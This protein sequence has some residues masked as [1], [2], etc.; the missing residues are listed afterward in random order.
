AGVR[1]R[2]ASRLRLSRLCAP[3]GGAAHRRHRRS[4][5]TVEPRRQFWDADFVISRAAASLHDPQL[6]TAPYDEA[7]LDLT[8]FVSCYNEAPY[9]IG[10]LDAVRG[11]ATEAG[12]AYEI[13]V[14]DDGSRDASTRLVSD[15]IAANPDERIVLRVNRG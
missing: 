6:M 9:I 8:V 12:L 11:A 5:M 14:I 3:A 10:T 4:G 2:Q 1:G 7:A 15:Y 13:I